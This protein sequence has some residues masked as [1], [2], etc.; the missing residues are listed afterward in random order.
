MKVH[1][2]VK[3]S[4]REGYEDEAIKN[5]NKEGLIPNYHKRCDG[6]MMKKENADFFTLNKEEVDCNRCLRLIDN[7]HK[8]NFNRINNNGEE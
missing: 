4:V 5:W 3:T 2:K 6:N 8:S 1:L 7:L